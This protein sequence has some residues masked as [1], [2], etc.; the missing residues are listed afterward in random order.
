MNNKNSK[1]K[2]QNSKLQSKIQNDLKIALKEGNVE[3]LSVLRMLQA[4]IHNQEIEKRTKLS[5]TIKDALEL[6]KL[7]KLT[8]EEILEVLTREAKKR[9]ESIV[10]FKKGVRED[11]AKKEEGELKI[12]SQY[13]P[14]QLSEEEIK[15]EIDKIV[16]EVKPSGPQDFGKI[17]AL[18]MAKMK[19]RAEGKLAGELLKEKLRKL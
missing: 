5:K 4:S 19:G 16:L 12:I 13:L 3:V 2:M 6:E 1:I 18:L 9:K 7:S 10:E 11:L 17:M 15:A 8:D 14:E